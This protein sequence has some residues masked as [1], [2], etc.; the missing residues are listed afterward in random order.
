M[1]IGTGVR[2]ASTIRTMRFNDSVVGVSPW[3]MP[4]ASRSCS[5]PRPRGGHT[6]VRISERTTH[7]E[8]SHFTGQHAVFDADRGTRIDDERFELTML[9]RHLGRRR[10]RFGH[11]RQQRTI[12]AMPHLNV[13]IEASHDGQ[14]SGRF[15]RDHMKGA[16]LVATRHARRH[17]VHARLFINQNEGRIVGDSAA[18]ATSSGS[19]ERSTPNCSRTSDC[20]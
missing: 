11:G 9:D 16:Q 5:P 13:E 17:R 20:K 19:C 15:R 14:E 3:I 7:F 18:H 6:G 10:M 4:N 8:T 2:W 12:V 1:R